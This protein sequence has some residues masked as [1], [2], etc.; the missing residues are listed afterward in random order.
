VVIDTLV[1]SM[2]ETMLFLVTGR[3][4]LAAVLIRY[5]HAVA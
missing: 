3:L 2:S 1:A 5:R 4:L